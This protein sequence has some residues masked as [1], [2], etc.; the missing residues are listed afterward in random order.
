MPNDNIFL[1]DIRV[2]R[3][4]NV[5]GVEGKESRQEGKTRDCSLYDYYKIV[6]IRG[7]TAK[8]QS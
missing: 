2:L 3:E 4:K 8:N 6:G 5:W 1:G 7:E